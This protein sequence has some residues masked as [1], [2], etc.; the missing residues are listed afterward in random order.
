MKKVAVVTNIMAPYRIPL[1]NELIKYKEYEFKVFFCGLKTKDRAWEI[2][3]NI[4]FQF[5][6]TSNKFIYMKGRGLK[7]GRAIPISYGLYNDLNNYKP[8][9]VISSE[10]SVP[11]IISS[12]YCKIN[13]KKYISWSDGTL[14]TEKNISS[15]QK[16]LRKYLIKNSQSFIAS[17]SDTFDNYLYYGAK[18]ELIF[19]SLLTVDTNFFTTEKKQYQKGKTINLVYCGSLN[20]SKGIYNLLLLFKELISL[21]EDLG[22]IIVGD[23]PERNKMEEMVENLKLGEKVIFKGFLQPPQLKEVYSN[24]DLLIFPSLSD[25]FGLVVNEAM[26]AGL[27]IIC[28]QYAGAARDLVSDENGLIINPLR[29]PEELSK[30]IFDKF[31]KRPNELVELGINSRNKILNFSPS[32]VSRGFY[33]ACK[34][35]EQ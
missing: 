19:K 29:N 34:S 1:F 8:D 28:S 5:K 9:I 20:E 24:S 26:C 13:R 15:L 14:H 6:I 3:N 2:P 30:E 31:L 21:K 33:L 22:L 11:S 32:L 17:S 25:T 23:G 16:T 4:N 7:D 10:F 35:I 27:P 18:R 12:I